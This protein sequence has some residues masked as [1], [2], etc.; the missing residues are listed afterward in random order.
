MLYYASCRQTTLLNKRNGSYSIQV[1]NVFGDVPGCT[2]YGIANHFISKYTT[3][4]LGDYMNLCYKCKCSNDHADH[5]PYIVMMT[6]EYFS[7]IL[8]LNPLKVQ[9]LSL[10]D[11]SMILEE[12]K[13]GFV[14]GQI[15][16][17]SLLNSPM[18]CGT[19]I[20]NDDEF[21]EGLLDDLQ[22]LFEKNFSNNLWFKIY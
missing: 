8:K 5:C 16:D 14:F 22:P 2:C 6:R 11:I 15:S 13:Y 20:I 4:A 21:F 18:L 19:N 1:P 3:N 12:R 9:M 7:S 17:T 10:L